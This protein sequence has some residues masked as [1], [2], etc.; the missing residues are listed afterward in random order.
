MDEKILDLSSEDIE[1]LKKKVE[2]L[3]PEEQQEF[4]NKLVESVKGIEEALKKLNK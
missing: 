4:L 3:S 2:T 1:N